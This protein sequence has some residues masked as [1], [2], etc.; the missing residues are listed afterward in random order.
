MI[1]AAATATSCS[2]SP[3][4]SVGAEESDANALRERATRWWELR[5]AKD[6]KA[7]Y[8]LWDP[9]FKKRV[10]LDGF[11]S[12]AGSTQY[13]SFKIKDVAIE[14]DYGY[15]SVEYVARIGLLIPN[16]DLEP[17]TVTSEHEWVKADGV[18]YFRCPD[19]PLKAAR[20]AASGRRHR[21]AR[22]NAS[23]PP[24]VPASEKN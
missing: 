17:Q 19:D 16:L 14:G 15:V 18:W 22:P 10:S 21:T 13:M 20:D 9:D 5:L 1:V 11:L 6:L 8:D 12:G 24:E 23:E 2:R 3:A 4:Q 7:Q